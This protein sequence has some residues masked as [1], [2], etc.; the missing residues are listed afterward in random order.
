[1]FDGAHISFE[2]FSVKGDLGRQKISDMCRQLARYQPAFYSV[3][4]GAGGSTRASTQQLVETIQADG[5]NAAPHLSF[6]GDSAGELVKTL[7]AYRQKGIMQVVAL[8]GDLPSGIAGVGQLTHANEL[9]ALIRDS[10]GA[11]FD[12][13][14]AAYPEVHPE[15]ESYDRDVYW[16]G[17]KLRAGANR[18]ITQY[19]YN[20]DAYFRFIDEAAKQGI[21]APIIPGI[22]PL[23]NYHNLVRF[24]DSCGAEIPRWLRQQLQQRSHDSADLMRFGLDVVSELCRK[25][26]EG[27]APGLHFYTMNNIA[28]IDALCQNLGLTEQP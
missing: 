19:F 22:M 7:E 12:I 20:P 15:A 1:M 8:R 2:F 14:V 9:V 13:S 27:G 23:T 21:S 26:L 3:T 17:E 5:F 25:L 28:V 16:L 24:S 4:Y 11:H 18:A 6:G 10:F